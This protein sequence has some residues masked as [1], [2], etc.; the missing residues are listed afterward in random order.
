M[1]SWTDWKETNEADKIEYYD[2]QKHGITE[3]FVR[4][5]LPYK[6]YEIAHTQSVIYH[7]KSFDDYVWSLVYKDIENYIQ[8]GTDIIGDAILNKVT[9]EKT[10]WHTA[11]EE[12]KKEDDLTA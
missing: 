11:E 1:S 3:I 6:F 8:N 5:R 2:N 7:L 4:V 12:E 9:G 10:Y